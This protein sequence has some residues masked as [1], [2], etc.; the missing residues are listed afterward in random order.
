MAFVITLISVEPVSADW[1]FRSVVY[2]EN[3]YE[4]TDELVLLSDIEKKIGKVTRYSD[5]EGTYPGNFSN[6][7]P[8]GTE[9]YSIKDKDPKEIIAVKAN[10]N[11]FVKAVNRGHY[12]NDYLETQNRIWIFI[13]GG[14]IVAVMISILFFRRRK[15]HI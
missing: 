1:A 14:I 10:K 6:T 8:V 4:V 13:I 12:D 2:S 15:K 9:Y 5:I 11:T 7:F 3:L